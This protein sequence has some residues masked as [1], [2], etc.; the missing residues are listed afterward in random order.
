MGSSRKS[1][2]L[3]EGLLRCN[4]ATLLTWMALKTC[5]AGYD[6]EC[7]KRIWFL[8]LDTNWFLDEMVKDSIQQ[9][10]FGKNAL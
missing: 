5:L 1:V 7:Y 3:R 9:Y 10:L 4:N 6:F 8:S 2:M